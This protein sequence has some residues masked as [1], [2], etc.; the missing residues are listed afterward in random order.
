M[1]KIDLGEDGDIIMDL[2]HKGDSTCAYK[3]GDRIKKVWGEPGDNNP[4][5]IKGRITGSIN[6]SKV[7]E[8]YLVLFEGWD[9]ETFIVGK[10]IGKDE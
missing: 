7:G 9:V 1:N 5:G 3:I 8:G 2:M 10:K 6:N 4:I